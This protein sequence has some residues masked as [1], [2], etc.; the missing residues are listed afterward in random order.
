MSVTDD[1]LGEDFSAD[2]KNAKRGNDEFY[3]VENKTNNMNALSQKD[4]SVVNLM[5]EASRSDKEES[6]K[7]ISGLK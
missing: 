2:A 3:V 4:E 1:L 6:A 5:A 7:V